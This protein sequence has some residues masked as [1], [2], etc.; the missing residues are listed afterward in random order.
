MRVATVAGC[1]MRKIW[2]M[3]K[4]ELIVNESQVR[5]DATIASSPLCFASVPMWERSDKAWHGKRDLQWLGL[6]SKARRITTAQEDHESARI[7]S[8]F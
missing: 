4:S 3:A 8:R 5:F 6:V 7:K 1:K 2:C